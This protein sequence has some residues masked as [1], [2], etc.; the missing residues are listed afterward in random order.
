MTLAL[1]IVGIIILI[2]SLL[3]IFYLSKSDNVVTL[4]YKINMC[5]KEINEFLGAENG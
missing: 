2:G 1:Y 5:D 4:M 3:G